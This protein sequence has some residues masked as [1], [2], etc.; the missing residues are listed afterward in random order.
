MASSYALYFHLYWWPV[1]WRAYFIFL[2]L[3]GVLFLFRVVRQ[4][5]HPNWGIALS[6]VYSFALSVDRVKVAFNT[7][8]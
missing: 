8:K 4:S 3:F 2:R 7:I 5:S 6:K 1:F